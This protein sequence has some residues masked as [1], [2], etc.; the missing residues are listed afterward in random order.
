MCEYISAQMLQQA[1]Q[2]PPNF[3]YKPESEI[4]EWSEGLG[5]FFPKVLMQKHIE[6]GQGELDKN[7]IVELLVRYNTLSK[8]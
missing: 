2:R 6:H 1:A 5:T 4:I 7:L 8:F 3:K